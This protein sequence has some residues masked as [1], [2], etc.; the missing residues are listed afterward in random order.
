MNK[1]ILVA[2]GVLAVLELSPW[3][4]QEPMRFQT[5]TSEVLHG[6]PTYQ[7]HNYDAIHAVPFVRLR[8]GWE[9]VCRYNLQCEQ[10]L[11][12]LSLMPNLARVIPFQPSPHPPPF[13]L[14]SVPDTFDS[15]P[16]IGSQFL[17]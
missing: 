5:E 13:K 16:E 7:A 15:I 6:G 14:G 12:L 10:Q 2:A 4:Q 1:A 3:W 11:C 17:L 8:N 9:E